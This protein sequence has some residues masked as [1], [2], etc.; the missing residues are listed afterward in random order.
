MILNAN[1]EELSRVQLTE[2][3]EKSTTLIQKALAKLASLDEKQNFLAD[4][5][6]DGKVNIKD[7]TAI[8]KFLA[9]IEIPYKVGELIL[10]EQ[11]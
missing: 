6:E 5:T 1:D 7:A 4:V 11:E 10:V 2:G 3:Q 9:K 8:Q